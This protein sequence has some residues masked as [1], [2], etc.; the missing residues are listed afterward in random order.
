MADVAAMAHVAMVLV[1]AFSRDI[2][3]SNLTAAEE[4]VRS[5]KF[6]VLNEII[7]CDIMTGTTLADFE[8][9]VN[10]I[11]GLLSPIGFPDYVYQSIVGGKFAEVNEE[12]I[13]DFRYSKG[14]AGHFMY[15]RFATVKPD[16]ATINLAY[17]VY[18]LE[19]EF[20]P[21][22]IEHVKTR[23]FLG[24]TIGEKV[25]R[26]TREIDLSIKEQD[27]LRI[28]FLSKAV[29]GFKEQYADLLEGPTQRHVTDRTTDEL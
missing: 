13:R 22:V 9:V 12:L 26:E 28:Y 25:W 24:F 17:S 3:N 23:K 10:S 4:Y 21:H 19:F 11:S 2:A 20:S 5:L 16:D 29:K 27:W 6:D 1:S 8:T 7:V 15:G 18:D 14:E